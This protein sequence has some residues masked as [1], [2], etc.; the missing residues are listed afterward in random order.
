MLLLMLFTL[1]LLVLTVD[2]QYVTNSP[3]L[4]YCLP[5]TTVADILQFI[6]DQITNKE[7]NMGIQLG[8]NA[9][10]RAAGWEDYI[11]SALDSTATSPRL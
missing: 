3:R 7:T 5:C 6:L 11:E 2:S 4:L 8:E 1:F 10:Q 9:I